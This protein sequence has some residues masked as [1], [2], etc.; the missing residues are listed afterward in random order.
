MWKQRKDIW[1]LRG[2]SDKIEIGKWSSVNHNI[3]TVWVWKQSIATSYSDIVNSAASWS[4]EKSSPF[5][6]PRGIDYDRGS[7]LSRK[8]A[9]YFNTL[10]SDWFEDD[11]ESD[12]DRIQWVVVC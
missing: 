7:Q 9:R 6:S 4:I 10:I 3:K 8:S 5:V 2:R 12:E 11:L 1:E